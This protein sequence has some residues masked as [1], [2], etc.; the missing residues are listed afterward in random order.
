M[1]VYREGF[2]DSLVLWFTNLYVH[3]R[4]ARHVARFRRRVGYW[5]NPAI[6][7]RYHEKMLWRKIFDRDPRFEVFCDKLATKALLADL[8][9]DLPLPATLWTGDDPGAIPPGTQVG[10]ALLKASHGC[11]YSVRIPEGTEPSTTSR[12]ITDAWLAEPWGVELMEWGY[13]RVPR[14]LLLEAELPS[15]PQ[16]PLLLSLIHI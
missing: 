10:A 6:P 7:V 13:H 16:S 14:T 5:P 12:E 3:V 4:F 15:T 1:R 11:N 2:V 8:N 9:P